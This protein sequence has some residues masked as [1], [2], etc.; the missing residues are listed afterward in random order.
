MCALLQALA[1]KAAWE[2]QRALDATAAQPSPIAA[3]VAANGAAAQQLE[4]SSSSSVS[5]STTATSIPAAAAAES[6]SA[7]EQN[8][9]K[10]NDSK[11]NDSEQKDSQKDSADVTAAAAAAAPSQGVWVRALG[12]LN[13]KGDV[14]AWKQY[15]HSEAH[16]SRL[17]RSATKEAAVRLK[18]FEKIAKCTLY[19]VVQWSCCIAGVQRWSDRLQCIMHLSS[20]SGQ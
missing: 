8:D 13:C 9:S 6:G 5:S 18:T 3:A 4:Q 2:Q 1:V 14:P 10:Q 12:Q 16:R 20:G 7:A 11:H 17:R 15:I 19:S